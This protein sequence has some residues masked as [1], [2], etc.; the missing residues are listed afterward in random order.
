MQTGPQHVKPSAG[1]HETERPNHR[2][3]VAST[4][5]FATP[6][7]LPDPTNCQ[8]PHHA[9]PHGRASTLPGTQQGTRHGTQH[10]TPNSHCACKQTSTSG[11]V[12]HGTASPQSPHGGR[13]ASGHTHAQP[14]ASA[15]LTQAA[16]YSRV[17][18]A[19][20][21][22]HVELP[23]KRPR[24]ARVGS[25]T[26]SPLPARWSPKRGTCVFKLQDFEDSS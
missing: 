16:G 5:V 6:M 8:R 18:C 21:G 15:S 2:G 7:W 10:G 11:E 4:G 13:S 25:E 24:S 3:Q 1:R 20:R 26:R 14:L 23:G 22:C 19:A 17:A 12:T 9:D